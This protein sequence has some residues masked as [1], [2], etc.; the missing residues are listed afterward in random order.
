MQTKNCKFCQSEIDKKAKV[1]PHCRK[2]QGSK[3]KIAIIAIIVFGILSAALGGGDDTDPSKDN[4]TVISN[5]SE[6]TDTIETT[7]KDDTLDDVDN[8]NSENTDGS[9][10]DSSVT[11]DSN[12][13]GSNTDGNPDD[14]ALDNE[15]TPTND[16]SKD[17]NFENENSI[18]DTSNDNKEETNNE[19][20]SYELTISAGNYTAGIDFP[21]GIYTITAVN[22][23]G[24]VSSSNMFDGG[25]NEV[26][27]V[28]ED[29]MYIKEFKNANLE[30]DVILNISGN[31]TVLLTS[32]G[33]NTKDMAPRSEMLSEEQT[34]SSGNYITGTDFDP[35]IYNI[36]LVKGS[37][38]VSSSNMFDGGLNEIFGNDDEMYI[39]EFKNAI[40]NNGDSLEISGVT[41]K[42]VPVK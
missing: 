30:K 28:V 25:L 21:S 37:G 10:G 31:V 16:K 2:A 23:S 39:K 11:D 15:G 41:I 18:D 8:T 13:D 6:S 5:E 33:V 22:G 42:L 19:L 36:I 4:T 20:V 26:M 27:S 32:D 9:N 17:D 12:A 38:N 34:F 3:I 29:E 1:C 24:N 35:G 14:E 40:F 7:D